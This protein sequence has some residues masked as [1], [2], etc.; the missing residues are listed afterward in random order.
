MLKE[1]MKRRRGRLLR[2]DERK[3]EKIKYEEVVAEDGED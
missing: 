1:L 3:Q 2:K